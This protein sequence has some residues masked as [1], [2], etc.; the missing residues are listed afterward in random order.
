MR[1]FCAVANNVAGVINVAQELGPEDSHTGSRGSSLI[2]TRVCYEGPTRLRHY[3]LACG[4]CYYFNPKGCSQRLTTCVLRSFVLNLRSSASRKVDVFR[5]QSR[6][7]MVGYRQII[8][9]IIFASHDC[10]H[11]CAHRLPKTHAQVTR[12]RMSSSSIDIMADVRQF[13]AASPPHSV[14]ATGLSV[15]LPSWYDPD[16][17]APLLFGTLCA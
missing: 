4:S 14:T 6:Q 3:E 1:G 12:R 5:I 16:F 10:R 17:I 15:I 8:T 13:S 9:L 11:A 7:M 2:S